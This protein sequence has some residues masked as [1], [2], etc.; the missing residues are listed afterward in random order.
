MFPAVPAAVHFCLR[1]KNTILLHTGM[2][3]GIRDSDWFVVQIIC[4]QTKT[5]CNANIQLQTI[6]AI[7]SIKSMLIDQFP[8][9]S[10]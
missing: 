3:F 10:P 4:V 6:F 8:L 5:D 2:P 7:R 1:L 9:F